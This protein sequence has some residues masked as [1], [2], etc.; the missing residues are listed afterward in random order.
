MKELFYLKKI[1]KKLIDFE[2]RSSR[3]EFFIHIIIF[4]VLNLII[5]LI[6]SNFLEEYIYYA[7]YDSPSDIL[8]NSI[9]ILFYVI[10]LILSV[11][12]ISVCVRRIH[13][14]GYSGFLLIPF[15]FGLFIA[16]LLENEIVARIS[17]IF[18]FI[19]ILNKPNQ[20]KLFGNPREK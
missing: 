18:F 17:I 11:P 12:I 8:Y 2:G 3:I 14:V 9:K 15:L 16:F 13:D 5:F 6:L 10:S 7:L 19:F 4:S 20:K 1:F